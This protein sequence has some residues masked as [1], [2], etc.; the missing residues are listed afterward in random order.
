M[1]PQFSR[2]CPS[3]FL[4]LGLVAIIVQPVA[5]EN[6][7]IPVAEWVVGLLAIVLLWQGE[8]SDFYAARS[9]HD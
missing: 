3:P 4:T 7:I 2:Q 5:V 6:K 9:R 8:S 1:G